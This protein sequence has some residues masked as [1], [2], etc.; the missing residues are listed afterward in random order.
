MRMSNVILV[1][2]WSP[3]SP[4][5]MRMMQDFENNCIHHKHLKV[6]MEPSNRAENKQINF[7]AHIEEPK[8]AEEAVE[9]VESKLDAK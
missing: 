3:Y 6:L 8:S 4:I 7:V 2:M 1:P 9:K 5:W